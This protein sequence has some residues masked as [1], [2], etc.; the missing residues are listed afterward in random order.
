MRRISTQPRLLLWIDRFVGSPLCL[1]FTAFRGARGTTRAAF[2]PRSILFLK[3]AEQGSTVL[4][5]DALAEAVARVG[6]DNVY[7]LAFEENRFVVDLLGLLPAAN[8]LPVV[9]RSP[10]AMVRSTWR[11]LREIRRRRIDACIDLEFFTRSSALLAVLSGARIRV[12]FHTYFGEGPYRGDLMTHRMLYN[13][14][15]HTSETFLSLVRALD[16]AP[17]QFPTFGF[18][19]PPPLPLPGFLP[20]PAECEEVCALLRRSS[21]E[22]G[23]ARPPFDSAQGLREVALHPVAASSAA[24]PVRLVLL[25]ANCSDLLPLRKWPDGN[26][27]ALAQRLVASHPDL[28]VVF[29]GS[30][31]EMARVRQLAAAVGS[32]RAVSLAGQTTLRQLLV[33]YCRAEILITNDSGPAHFAA[34]TPIDVIALFG[35]ETPL[36]FAAHGPRSHPVWAGIACSPCVNAFNSRQSAC[37]NNACMQQI[38]VTQVGELADRIL[39]ARALARAEV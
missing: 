15:L 31:D 30:A 32:P 20:A 18:R 23:Q 28:T 16:V 38:S 3:L 10:G 12:G 7:F 35:P 29:T 2:Q 11:L 17:A 4:A 6:R 24:A 36:L 19:P 21:A 34:L 25:N 37:R 33:L 22:G 26:Y 39:A 9:T 8:V 1:L 13:P 5:Y 27:V 14:H